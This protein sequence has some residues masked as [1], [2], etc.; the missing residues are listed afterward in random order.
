MPSPNLPAPLSATITSATVTLGGSSATHTFTNPVQGYLG[1]QLFCHA[2]SDGTIVMITIDQT[3]PNSP[4]PALGA[5]IASITV[6]YNASPTPEHWDM[7]NI[8]FKGGSTIA[9]GMQI[10]PTWASAT[11]SM[12]DAVQASNEARLNYVL[13]RDEA[14]PTTG[15]PAHYDLYWL[16]SVALFDPDTI[17][18]ATF[19]PDGGGGMSGPFGISMP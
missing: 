19:I 18:G 4:P 5:T 8:A 17:S 12:N 10:D 2:T 15:E 3:G 9:L 1:D 13:V 14:D 11:L 16:T 6:N 7:Q